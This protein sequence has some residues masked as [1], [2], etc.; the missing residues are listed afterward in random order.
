MTCFLITAT[1]L[2]RLIIKEEIGLVKVLA[3][4]LCIG[5]TMMILRPNLFTGDLQQHLFSL[6]PIGA[7]ILGATGVIVKQATVIRTLP[8][9]TWILWQSIF[10]LIAL[11][12]E[13][14]ISKPVLF[15]PALVDL[16]FILLFAVADIASEVFHV[17]SFN[18][19]TGPVA[20][21]AYS[22]SLV[23]H[24]YLCCVFNIQY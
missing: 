3:A 22:S 18:F 2:S 16:L 1:V 20:I 14:F 5:G 24:V 10:I 15:E 9:S 7:G 12:M 4:I 13:T 6:M 17:H 21:M 8:T 23:F 11:L 19:T